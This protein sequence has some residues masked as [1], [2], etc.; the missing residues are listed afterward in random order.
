[1]PS[2]KRL[3]PFG[4]IEISQELYEE[5]LIDIDKSIQLDSENAYAYRHRGRV[6]E[7]LGQKAS[8][9]SDFEKAKELDP[10]VGK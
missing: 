4:N 9:K 10:N 2:P 8:A 7:A 1:M 5:A 6:K 3:I